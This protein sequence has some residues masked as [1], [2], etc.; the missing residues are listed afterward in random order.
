MHVHMILLAIVLNTFF[1]K[2][3]FFANLLFIKR[4]RLRV[5]I[6]SIQGQLNI[7]FLDFSENV[8]AILFLSAAFNI[9]N[10]YRVA[11]Y[12]HHDVDV[13]SLANRLLEHSE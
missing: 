10:N 1:F 13:F 9:H 6:Q 4:E 11:C 12:L 3:I 5:G 2:I 7:F 8:F